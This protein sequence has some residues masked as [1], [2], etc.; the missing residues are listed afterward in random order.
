MPGDPYINEAGCI[1]MLQQEITPEFLPYHQNAALQVV[2][3]LYDRK[4]TREEFARNAGVAISFYATLAKL[5]VVEQT[6]DM[7]AAGTL[8]L[9]A[10]DTS[11]TKLTEIAAGKAVQLAR[12]MELLSQCPW[13]EDAVH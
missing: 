10:I 3:D 11:A 4:V 8:T 9:D 13:S 12:F 5:Y 6:R 7:S 2:M 1:Q